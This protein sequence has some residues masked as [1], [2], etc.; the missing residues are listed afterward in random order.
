MERKEQGI[1][2]EGKILDRE[3]KRKLEKVDNIKIDNTSIIK[4]EEKLAKRMTRNR[5]ETRQPK[6]TKNNTKDS[7]FE[8]NKLKI[9]QKITSNNGSLFFLGGT[10]WQLRK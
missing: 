6:N 4:T 7:I 9:K 1:Y 3:L 2:E 10:K 5:T 8:K